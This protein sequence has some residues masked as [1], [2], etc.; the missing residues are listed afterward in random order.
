MKALFA[1][2]MVCLLLL[3]SNISLSAQTR[4][5]RSTTQKRRTT[6]SS[7]SSHLDATQTNAARIKLGDQ[8]KNLTKFLYLYGRFSKD[9]ELTGAQA[10]ADDTASAKTR[11]SLLNTI[12]AIREGLDGLE[13]QFRLTPG[14]QTQYA[15]LSGVAQLAS[16]A[17]TEASA[18]HL[19]R[20]GRML[21]EVVNRLTDVLLEM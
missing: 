17:E 20:A 15:N 16:D 14:L 7:S 11:A 3:G 4:A 1:T 2:L 10:G 21:I 5:R 6:A 19:D 12:R 9:L 18:N 13:A 8:I